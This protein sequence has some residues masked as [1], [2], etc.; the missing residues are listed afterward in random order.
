MNNYHYYTVNLN[1]ICL[2][3]GKSMFVCRVDNCNIK[4]YCMYFV[5]KHTTAAI[6]KGARL[7]PPWYCTRA[8]QPFSEE[9]EQLGTNNIILGG[10]I[11]ILFRYCLKKDWKVLWFK[12]KKKLVVLLFLCMFFKQNQ[13]KFKNTNKE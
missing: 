1:I 2:I 6:K 12:K 4:P 13:L 3:K 10:H 9:G 11:S 5:H 7:K 8:L